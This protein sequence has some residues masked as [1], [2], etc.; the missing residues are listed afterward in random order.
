MA[1]CASLAFAITL[2]A[3]FGAQSRGVSYGLA[4]TARLAF[5]FFWPAYVGGALT[6]LFGN[7]FLPLRENARNFGLAFAGALLVHLGLVVRLCAIGHS[8][9]AKTFVIFGTAAAWVYILMLLSVRRV[10]DALPD[11]FWTSV[12]SVAMSYIALAFTFDF[13]KFPDDLRHGVQYAPF[14]Y[15][16]PRSGSQSG[17]VDKASKS[18]EIHYPSTDYIT[19]FEKILRNLQYVGDRFYKCCVARRDHDDGIGSSTSASAARRVTLGVVIA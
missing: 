19:L 10:R 18:E 6:S 15:G 3:V 14:A 2:L 12:R 16:G 9:D 1:F 4:G 11:K 17:C 8:P 5:L 7:L 13:A